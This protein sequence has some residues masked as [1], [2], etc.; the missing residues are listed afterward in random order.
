M[1]DAVIEFEVEETRILPP[2][3]VEQPGSFATEKDSPWPD[4]YSIEGEK[5]ALADLLDVDG[6]EADPRFPRVLELERRMEEFAEISARYRQRQGAEAVV[7]D[8][9]ALSV[10]SMGNLV[11]DERDSM[12]VHTLEAYRLF[13]GR[14]R[15]PDK[16][17]MHIPGGKSQASA[18]KSLWLLSANDNPY[19]DWS[20]L[21][22]EDTHKLL[23]RRLRDE[24]QTFMKQ[25]DEVKKTGLSINI[26]SSK[27]PA[28]LT[29]GFGSPYGYAVCKLIVEFDLYVRTVKT[30]ARKDELTDEE[31]RKKIYQ[32]TRAIRAAWSSIHRFER[33]LR[34]PE[35]LDMS[36]SDFLPGQSSPS[37]KRAQAA[38]EL[39][40][41]MPTEIFDGSKAPRHSRRRR[42]LTAQEQTLLRGIGESWEE[43]DADTEE[44]EADLVQ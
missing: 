8:R 14:A 17:L 11:D 34:R 24:T 27:S 37:Q 13:M 36:R 44:I 35:L 26:L 5:K 6:G 23:H 42:T 39:L 31:A 21:L 4:G 41:G 19:A 40:P 38:K 30:L 9:E 7:S 12:C 1:T 33:N 32:M 20:L 43:A 18:L 3:T 25:I 15:S 16:K 10:R 22:H 2:R 29:L 28:V